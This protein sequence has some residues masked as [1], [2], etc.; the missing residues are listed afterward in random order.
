MTLRRKI[1]GFEMLETRAMLAGNVV[2]AVSDGVLSLTGDARENWI[3]IQ[4]VGEFDFLVIGLDSPGPGGSGDL[5]PTKVNGMAS[6]VFTGVSDFS[7]KMRGEDDFLFFNGD[8]GQ[9]A[10]GPILIQGSVDALGNTGNDNILFEDTTIKKSL[11]IRGNDGG[12]TIQLIDSTVNQIA[13]I[14]G[15]NQGDI[16]GVFRS[17][18]RNDTRIIG[19]D[20]PDQIFI[21]LQ[22]G[23]LEGGNFRKDLYVNGGRNQDFIEFTDTRVIGST[24][25]VGGGEQDNI[26]INNSTF[27]SSV[28][29]N[30][31]NGTDVIEINDGRFLGSANQ[32][33]V[34]S[35]ADN[36]TLRIFDSLFEPS[37]VVIRGD[38]GNDSLA[39]NTSV[40]SN[41]PSSIRF[42]GGDGLMD[43]LD[44]GFG[45]DGNGNVFPGGFFQTQ[46]E[47]L[48]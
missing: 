16:I 8:T 29:L 47:E 17:T 20:G 7:I 32:L 36:D 48:A 5:A 26:D 2:G 21:G 4:Q 22:Q 11:R 27:K 25:I 42:I 28:I 24:R 6:Q 23:S 19:G 41:L 18:L 46:W 9:G 44:T 15:Q 45:T 35:G 34:V 39:I 13:D 43:I 31:G 12:D 33:R 14:R 3:E 38:A 1:R 30:A 40:F 37:Q 10:L